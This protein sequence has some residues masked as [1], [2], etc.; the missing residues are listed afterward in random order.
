MAT[1]TPS[2]RSAAPA[3]AP[4]WSAA[5]VETLAELAGD[6]RPGRLRPRAALAAEALGAADPPRSGSSGSSSA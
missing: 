3:P 6:V 1:P 5:E 4:G 2:P